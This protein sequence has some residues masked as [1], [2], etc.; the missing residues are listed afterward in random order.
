MLTLIIVLSGNVGAG[1]TTL[2]NLL[3]DRFS[4]VHIKT[5]SLL[6]AI[7][8]NI[9]QE[10]A[11]LQSFGE[12]LDKKT[13]GAWVRDGLQRRL[14]ELK[15]D[16]LVVLDSVRIGKQIEAIRASYGRKVVHVHLA[17]DLSVLP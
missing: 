6:T 3:V 1:K 15:N 9:P 5:H 7:G 11:A 16:S 12:M 13:K 10:R 14:R 8:S 17:A 4:A 2:A